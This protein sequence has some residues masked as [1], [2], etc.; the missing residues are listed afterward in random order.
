MAAII[1]MLTIASTAFSVISQISQANAQADS[2]ESAANAARYNAEINRQRSVIAL[3]QGN[4]NEETKRRESRVKMGNL[5]AGLIENGIGLEGTASDLVEASSLN[6]ELD[7]LNIRYESQL[8][9]RS[10]NQQAALDD[11]SAQSAKTR[12]K[13]ART[14]GYIGA[15]SSALSG[16]TKYASLSR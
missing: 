16:A 5:R 14:A 3:Q 12:A 11:Q 13:Q 4:A 7:A 6:S 10:Y 15:A 2:E 9:A 8:N 1:P